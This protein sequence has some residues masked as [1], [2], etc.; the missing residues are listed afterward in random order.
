MSKIDLLLK[1][2][3]DLMD[4]NMIQRGSREG[5]EIEKGIVLN[6]DYLERNM[7]NIG[8]VMSIFTAYPDVFLDFITPEDSNFQLF[9]Y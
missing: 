6:E 9:F 5:I 4:S 2:K 7:E 3:N 1:K 8:D